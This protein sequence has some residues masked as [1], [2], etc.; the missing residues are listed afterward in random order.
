MASRSA[1]LRHV[2]RRV[3][4]WSALL[5]VVGWCAGPFVWE[6]LTSMKDS[7]DIF[8]I[9]PTYL[10]TRFSLSAYGLVLTQRPF[11]RYLANSLVVASGSSVLAVACG[12]LAAYAL[13]RFRVRHARV[14]QWGLLAV[15]FVPPIVLIVP[16]YELM[17]TLRWMNTPQAL[18]L[19]YA[20]LNLPFAVWVLASYLRQLPRD[21]EDAAQ[22][23]GFTRT[24]LLV[25]IVAPLAAPALATTALLVFIFSWNE[26]LFALAFMTRDAAR[27]LPVGVALLAGVTVYEIPWDQ[28]SAAIVLTTLPVVGLVMLLQRRILEGL[29]RGAVKG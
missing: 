12:G 27:T 13:V 3:A 21:L 11:L 4:L 10:P 7:A 14:L 1:D 2:A 24:G 19:P 26:F 16:L 8:A 23:D 9:P 5:A 22:I 28:I 29:T 15:V 25:R 17:S 20:A 6:L 18:I